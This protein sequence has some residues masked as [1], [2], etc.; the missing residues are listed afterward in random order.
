MAR[1]RESVHVGLAVGDVPA[2]PAVGAAAALGGGRMSAER[3]IMV[4]MQEAIV[5]QEAAEECGD[6]VGLV[7]ALG[8]EA[9]ML[10][11]LVVLYGTAVERGSVN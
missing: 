9:E 11:R 6:L 3:M 10:A 1:G 8:V 7:A 2:V 5:A 4:R